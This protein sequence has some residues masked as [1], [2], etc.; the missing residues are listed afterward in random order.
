MEDIS[1][2]DGDPLIGSQIPLKGEARCA[3]LAR[4]SARDRATADERE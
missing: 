1:A 3:N 2:G 4:V